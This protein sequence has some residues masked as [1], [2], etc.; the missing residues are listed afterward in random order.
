MW[1]NEY[2]T[3]LLNHT[4]QLNILKKPCFL[5]ISFSVIFYASKIIN[6]PN[7]TC[8][9]FAAASVTHQYIETKKKNQIEKSK[10]QKNRK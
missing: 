5:K 2:I 3:T 1:F 6:L 4:F 8:V 10:N 9:A 7:V